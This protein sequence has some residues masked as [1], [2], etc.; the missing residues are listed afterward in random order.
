[1][2]QNYWRNLVSLL[3]SQEY[4]NLRHNYTP[5]VLTSIGGAPIHKGHIQVLQMAKESLPQPNFV[6]VA[7]NSDSYT[8]KKHG[9]C[10]QNQEERAEI[11]SSIKYVDAV[12]I[13]ENDNLCDALELICPDY[14]VKG[15]DRTLDNLNK[16]ELMMCY[17]LDIKILYGG[18][19]I[20]SSSQLLEN[21]YSFKKE[22]ELDN[23]NRPLHRT[24]NK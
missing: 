19:K 16:E 20:Q 6:I 1:M 4:I 21:Y 17:D 15:G 11:I 2:L 5:I 12:Y 8:E 14:F 22:E 7:I 10:F 23:A 18:K 24:R 3:N 9:Y 13:E